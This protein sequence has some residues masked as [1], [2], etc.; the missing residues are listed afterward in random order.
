MRQ[1]IT[2]SS[3]FEVTSSPAGN[4]LSA[5]IAGADRDTMAAATYFREALR[6]DPNNKELLERAFIAALANGNMPDAFGFAERTLKRDPKNG[7]AHLVLGARAFKA[8]QY[9]AAR[10]QIALGGG[11]RQRDITALL[12]NAWSYAGAKDYRHAIEQVDRLTDDRFMGFRDYHAALITE[13]SGNHA[14]ALKRMKIA[15]D[16]ERTTLRV[17]DAYGRL[18]ARNGSIDEAKRVYTDF[19]HILPRHPIV[20]AALADLEAGRKLEPLVNSPAAGAAEVLYGLGAAGGQQNDELA[21]MIYLR[22]SLYLASDNALALVTLADIYERTK[23]YERAID[24]YDMVPDSSPLRANA[25]IQSGLVLDI[26]GRPD[27][28]LTY[29]KSI[30]A[31]RPN[32][33]DAV[34][35]LGNLQRSRKQFVE[36]AATYTRVINA[37]PRDQKGDWTIWYFRAICYER[38]KQWP[39]AEADFQK[40]LSLYPE[41][42]LV[43]NYLGY[44]WVDQG[45]NLDAAFVMLR[46]AVELRPSDGYVI[47]SLGWAY[48]KL[49]KYDEAMRELER[50]IEFKPG[51]PVINDHLGDIYWQVGRKLEAKFQW[52]HARDLKPEPDDLERILQKIENGLPEAPKPTSADAETQKNG[53]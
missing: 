10:A 45:L 11:G 19:D 39:Q 27:E 53:G 15:Y 34:L 22:L 30:V 1:A 42:P 23:Q 41:Q 50:A 25:D 3:S 52:N 37:S 49:G 8:K 13:L 17:V 26:L 48:Y 29:M 38:A 36:A 32:E 28:A 33:V 51:D 31:E 43:L 21:G 24:V 6:F 18:L 46:R 20:T 7:L 40:A 2:L 14:E 16:N 47:D 4:Y 12:I 35:A 44:S 9:P 5:L